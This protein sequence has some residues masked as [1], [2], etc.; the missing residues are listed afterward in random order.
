L[1]LSHSTPKF[2]NKVLSRKGKIEQYLSPIVLDLDDHAGNN[3]VTSQPSTPAAHEKS[4]SESTV[5]L[6]KYRNSG[7][8]G[9]KLKPISK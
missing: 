5:T 9:V 8:V 4:N 7:Y 3:E 2:V 1:Q 6:G